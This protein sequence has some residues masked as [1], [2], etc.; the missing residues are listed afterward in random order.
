M[1]T[2]SLTKSDIQAIPVHDADLI[3]IDLQPI[4][5]VNAYLALTIKL[6]PDESRETLKALGVQGD[7]FTI[8]FAGCWR[9]MLDL[10]LDRGGEH[11]IAD[12]VIVP[13]SPFLARLKAEGMGPSTE[14]LHHRF[15]FSSGSVIEV[16]AERISIAP[17][18]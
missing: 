18:S 15:E 13:D 4:P 17:A 11:M 8:R 12:W 14:V 2:A 3:A 1:K 9:L 16:V 5:A 10:L 7:T 6:H